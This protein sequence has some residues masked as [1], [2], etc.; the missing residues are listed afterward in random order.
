MLKRIVSLSL[1]ISLPCAWAQ[2]QSPDLPSDD[3]PASLFDLSL[4]ELLAVRLVTAANGFEQLQEQAPVAVSTISAEE[5]QAM[6]ASTL[7][8]AVGHLVGVHISKSQTGIANN[9]PVI[10]GVSGTFGQ[11]ILVLMDG[12]PFRRIRDGGSFQGHR[13]PLGG[14]KRTE[15]I[16]SPGSVTY[17]GEVVGVIIKMVTYR[18]AE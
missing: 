12:V 10:R 7:F 15:V 16:G 11:Q 3:L 13:I 17:G 1:F 5:W 9:K 6:G 4:K 18:P 2:S 8:D 14:I